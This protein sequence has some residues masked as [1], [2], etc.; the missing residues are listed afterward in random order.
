MVAV[1][2]LSSRILKILLENLLP[3]ALFE[4]CRFAI[5]SEDGAYVSVVMNGSVHVPV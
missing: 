1:E 2:I 4:L 5:L 3:S